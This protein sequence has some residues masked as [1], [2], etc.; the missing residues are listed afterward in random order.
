M[1]Q[2][3]GGQR[4]PGKSA[5]DIRHSPPGSSGNGQLNH[6]TALLAGDRRTLLV[7]RKSGRDKDHLLKTQ[8]PLDLLRQGNM[9]LVKGVEGSAEEGSLGTTASLTGPGDVHGHA[10]CISLL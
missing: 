10:P 6:V 7:R 8:F 9:A 2:G 5:F 1:G 4:W 3:P